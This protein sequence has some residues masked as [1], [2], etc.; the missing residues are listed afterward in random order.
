MLLKSYNHLSGYDIY[1]SIFKDGK[2]RKLKT[3]GSA[4]NSAF[5]DVDA[6]YGADGKSIYFSS[7]RTTGFGGFDLY[8]ASIDDAGNI[9]SAEN[10]GS[11]VNTEWD[12]KSPSF[13]DNGKVLF[14][15]SQ[16]KPGI[17]GYDFFYSKQDE[18]GKWGTVYNA[19]YP[20]S[21][22]DDDL[23]FS[24]RLQS[25]EGV[26]A[27]HEQQSNSDD[28]IFNVRFDVL[29]KFKLVPLRGEVQFKSNDELSYK[30]LNLYFIDETIKDTVGTVESPEGGKYKI[31]L[32]PG[33]FKLVMSREKS[34]SVSQA[35]TVPS[36]G[37]KPDY[38]LTSEFKP[39]TETPSI[40]SITAATKVKVDTI[41]V[42]DIL[43]EFDKAS[44]SVNEKD[45]VENLIH[46]LKNHKIDRI[47]LIGF[48]DCFGNKSYNKK[49]SEQRASYVMNLFIEKGISKGMLASKGMG[50]SVAAAKNKNADG[51]DNPNGRAY[52]RRV[53][54][55]INSSESNLVIIKKDIVPVQ[56]KP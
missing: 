5:H 48:T 36:D 50:D 27:K 41:Y 38:Q 12:E 53:E 51:S 15:S 46:K 11:T 30:G 16:R 8:K 18:N 52:N 28:D 3:I 14:F 7:N 32:Y 47:E 10:L 34:E 26:L 45:K 31:D 22:V 37:S 21:T 42:T 40:S 17:G 33:D 9:G 54:I 56:L 35:F 24:T 55:H 39:Q 25:N 13:N 20:L 19:G 29:S 43:F 23:G 2:W 6:V 49:L 1:E 44:I 4:V